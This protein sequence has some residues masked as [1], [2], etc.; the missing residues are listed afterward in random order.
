M[1]RPAPASRAPWIIHSPRCPVPRI[2]TDRPGLTSATLKTAPTPEVI[3]HP[4]SE[5]TSSGRS[6]CSGKAWLAVTFII[7]A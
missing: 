1:I 5:S 6:L 4:S 2:A 3:P 7:S